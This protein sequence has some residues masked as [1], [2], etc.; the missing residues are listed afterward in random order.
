MPPGP[1]LFEGFQQ[2]I[3]KGKVR[4]GRGLLLQTSCHNSLPCSIHI[5]CSCELQYNTCY[6]L[7]CNFLSLYEWTL[8]GQSSENRLS[9]I[10]QALGN[11]LLQK[12][13]SPHD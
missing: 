11:I 3:S 5:G 4:E 2:S 1:K 7:F 8:K 6:S 10:L 13:Q 9:C 12:V